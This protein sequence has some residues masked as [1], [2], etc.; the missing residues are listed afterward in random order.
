[1]KYSLGSP[2]QEY[3][4]KPAV[5]LISGSLATMHQWKGKG[6]H[7]GEAQRS[8]AK[9]Q[10]Q[11]KSTPPSLSPISQL[12]PQMYQQEDEARLQ[13]WCPSSPAQRKSFPAVIP[14]VNN[15]PLP[16]L[17]VLTQN[18]PSDTACRE[19]PKNF[20]PYHQSL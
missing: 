18:Q 19:I 7:P 11:R 9:H 16:Y 5:W 20:R 14:N 1:M 12:I 4:E 8:Q 2:Y 10:Q 15:L 3:S 17:N 6:I 13:H